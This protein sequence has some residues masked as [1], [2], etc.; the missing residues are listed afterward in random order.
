ML[1]IFFFSPFFFDFLKSGKAYLFFFFMVGTHTSEL[2]VSFICLWFSSSFSNSFGIV[3]GLR[4]PY[5]SYYLLLS[6]F[7]LNSI[8]FSL[9]FLLR[10]KSF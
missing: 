5:F 3:V 1:K 7:Y 6:D 8:I 9:A 2:K 10:S 4:D